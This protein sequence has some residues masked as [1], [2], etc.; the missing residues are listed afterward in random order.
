MAASIE[1]GWA[2]LIV[3]IIF[4][5]SV[6]GL[7]FRLRIINRVGDRNGVPDRPDNVGIVAM[8]TM[9]VANAIAMVTVVVAMVNPG[10]GDEWWTRHRREPLRSQ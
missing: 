3:S 9:T 5:C 6:F 7:S 10:T 1:N 2:T 4:F 8:V